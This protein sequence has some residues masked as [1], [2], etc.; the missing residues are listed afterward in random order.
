MIRTGL[1]YSPESRLR[2]R[3]SR[4]A[5]SAS[6]PRHARHRIRQGRCK[7]PFAAPSGARTRN[8][9]R[10]SLTLPMQTPGIFLARQGKTNGCGTLRDKPTLEGLLEP[11]SIGRDFVLRRSVILKPLLDLQAG[12]GI[13][14][15]R[16]LT[17]FRSRMPLL[18]SNGYLL[19]FFRD[20]EQTLSVGFRDT[21]A[22]GCGPG[23]FCPVA[24]K[25]W[26]PNDVG[27]PASVRFVINYS[28]RGCA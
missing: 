13:G 20:P 9:K 16:L 21:K 23:V 6:V 10:Q 19:I 2:I 3:V 1:L 24:P 11:Q 8:P 14:N 15:T 22:F 5:A 12:I 28:E 7:W 18:G 17:G 4:S 27:H 25:L 26:V